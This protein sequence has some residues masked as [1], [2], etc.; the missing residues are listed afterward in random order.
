MAHVKGSGTTS[1]GRDSQGQRLGVKLFGGQVAKSGNIIVRQRGTRYRA[2]AH[3]QRGSDDTL[4]ATAA[5]TVS[6]KKK[7]IKSFNGKTK[8]ANLVSIIPA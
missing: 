6:F 8:E 7:K 3:V 4:F 2:G 5:G 1:L